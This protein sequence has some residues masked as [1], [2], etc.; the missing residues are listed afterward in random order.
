LDFN[1]ASNPSTFYS[2]TGSSGRTS[3]YSTSGFG[4][5]NRSYSAAVHSASSTPLSSR[6]SS[7]RAAQ[8]GRSPGAKGNDHA[9]SDPNVT[10]IFEKLK[11]LQSGKEKAVKL[12]NIDSEDFEF[13]Y[14]D[15]TKDE[16]KRCQLDCQM[17][18]PQVW[19]TFRL[20]YQ[21]TTNTLMVECPKIM[22]EI[23]PRLVSHLIA[24]KATPF[25][26]TYL[27]SRILDGGAGDINLKIICGE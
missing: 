4:Q 26:K 20:D 15:Y 6:L 21:S 5:Q 14:K 7:S 8:L 18:R 23:A 22:H 16:N 19:L 27:G 1:K 9:H 2:P 10:K 17:P 11:P 13:F 24:E 25:F 12:Y 3:P